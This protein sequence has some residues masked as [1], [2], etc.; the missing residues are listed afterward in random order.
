MKK[1]LLAVAAVCLAW[2]AVSLT[3]SF[4]STAAVEEPG[5]LFITKQ[6]SY[7]AAIEDPG[8]MGIAKV[9]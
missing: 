3:V 4:T 7:V 6:I 8:P 9:R 1:M 5:P 2:G